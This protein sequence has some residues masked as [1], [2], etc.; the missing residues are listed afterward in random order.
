V[1]IQN[2]FFWTNRRYFGP[3][4][5]KYRVLLAQGQYTSDRM[6]VRFTTTYAIGTNHH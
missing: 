4:N 6:V 5:W 1:H 2:Q 3:F